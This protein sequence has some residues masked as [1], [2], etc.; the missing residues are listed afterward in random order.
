MMFLKHLPGFFLVLF[1]GIVGDVQMCNNS[2]ACGLV[3][4]NSHELLSLQAVTQEAKQNMI[5]LLL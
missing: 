3:N 2:P 1:G 4:L 5:L